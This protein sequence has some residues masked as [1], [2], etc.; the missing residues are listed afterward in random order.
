MVNYIPEKGDIVWLDFEPQK[1]K[2]IQ[3]TRPVVV[4]SPYK[5]IILKAV[6]LYLLL[7]LV[8]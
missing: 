1:G 3:K 8:K 6:L 2:E 7:L 4:L 5:N